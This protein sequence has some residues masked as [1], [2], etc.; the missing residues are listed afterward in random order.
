MGKR[1]LAGYHGKLL[2]PALVNLWVL[3]WSTGFR[4]ARAS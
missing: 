3:F 2:A 1:A 4:L